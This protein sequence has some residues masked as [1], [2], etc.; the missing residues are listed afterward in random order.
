LGCPVSKRVDVDLLHLAGLGAVLR[1]RWG[2]L[3]LQIPLSLLTALI[4]YDGLTGP[5]LAPLNMAT[6]LVWI[7][8]RGGVILALL[9]LGNLFCMGC[10]FALLRTVA[11]RLA[12]GGRRWPRP[13]RNKWG[14]IAL[15][16]VLLWLY[17]WLDLWASPWWTAWLVIG[18]FVA[19]SVTEAVFR[20]SPFCKYLCPLGAFNTLYAATS[21]TQIGSRDRQRCRSC[22]NKECVNGS[23]SV[24]GCGTELYV[25]QIRSNV[26]CVL[27]LD[28]ARA[29]PHDNV[30]LRGRR[31][32]QELSD[33]AWR[34]RWD[35]GLL[36]VILAFAGLTNALGMVPPMYTLV[37]WVG[38]WLRTESEGLVLLVIFSMGIL[39]LPVSVGLAAATVSHRLSAAAGSLRATLAAYAPVMVPIGLGIWAGHYGFHFATAALTFIPVSQYF[40][41][42]HGV[43]WFG[44]P[45][46]QLG[47]IVPAAWVLPLQIAAVVVGLAASL[48]V[49]GSVE[50]RLA[51][52]PR[53]AVLPWALVTTALA[54]AAIYV[55][56]LPMEMRGTFALGR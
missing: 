21:W 8:Y 17:E 36:A 51:P 20:E 24:P 35:L 15:I 14:A 5:Q 52:R 46:W 53:T 47:P 18:Y 25:P 42:D 33:H 6:V 2:R 11:L 49:L 16:F 30:A 45:D 38:S 50:A 37:G 56:T 3:G 55:F 29:C 43:G 4:V 7:H 27:C 34:S 48:R 31:P 26:D 39:I 54:L 1:W 41:Q 12:R 40:L 32:G 44:S 28:C 22:L 19:A 10:P 13:L 9:L 23:M